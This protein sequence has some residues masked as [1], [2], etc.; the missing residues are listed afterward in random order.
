MQDAQGLLRDVWACLQETDVIDSARPPAEAQAALLGDA[1][2]D[3]LAHKYLLLNRIELEPGTYLL[4]LPHRK[5]FPTDN[6]LKRAACEAI[7]QRLERPVMFDGAAGPDRLDP[8]DFVSECMRRQSDVENA[9]ITKVLV[10]ARVVT[11]VEERVWGRLLQDAVGWAKEID[12]LAAPQ[13]GR[14]TLA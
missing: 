11:A 9:P 13:G 2:N 12:A 1:L 5:P 6:A 8:T 4:P 14:G 3:F 10:H 7:E